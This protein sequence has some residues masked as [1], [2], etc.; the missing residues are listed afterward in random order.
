MA[1]R[2]APKIGRHSL[3]G[4]RSA[5]AVRRHSSNRLSVRSNL[6]VSMTDRRQCYAVG[7]DAQKFKLGPR[8]RSVQGTGA[9]PRKADHMRAVGLMVHGGPE[10]LEVV[11][12]PEV[13]AGPGQEASAKAARRGL[14]A[15]RLVPPWDWRRGKRLASETAANDNPKGCKIKGNIGSIDAA[16]LRGHRWLACA[17]NGSR[18]MIVHRLLDHSVGPNVGLNRSWSIISLLNQC[19]KRG[20]WRKGVSAT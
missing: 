14:W 18:L 19:V 15:G 20:K 16:S 7:N 13:H 12:L 4:S 17:R 9:L 8:I 11:D 3:F 2:I 5:F 6:Y 10:V 1:G